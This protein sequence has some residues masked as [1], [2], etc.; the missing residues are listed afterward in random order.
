LKYT[1]PTGHCG[2]GYRGNEACW[3]KYKELKR[4]CPDCA[5]HRTAEGVDVPLKELDVDKLDVLVEGLKGYAARQAEQQRQQQ[6]R[7][8]FADERFDPWY[9]IDNELRGEITA[10]FE[11]VYANQGIDLE[12]TAQQGI[13][14]P[15]MQPQ[16]S[17]AAAGFEPF[18]IGRRFHV[19][20]NIF[21]DRMGL[22][23]NPQNAENAWNYEP[24]YLEAM[25]EAHPTVLE[26][27]KDSYMN[28]SD[29]DYLI[30]EIIETSSN[31]VNN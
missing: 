10:H 2:K 6:I 28:R 18:V 1:D 22:S 20:H 14:N 11:E 17:T 23:W 4:I 13:D 7:Q 3:K 24:L 25:M 9:G 15:L 21:L 30:E 27:A 29:T 12:T 8:D 5:A 31:A 16:H 26:R 19:P